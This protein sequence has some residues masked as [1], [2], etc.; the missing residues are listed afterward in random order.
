MLGRLSTVAAVLALAGC[1]G[2]KPVPPLDSAERDE[3]RRLCARFDDTTVRVRAVYAGHSISAD[4]YL[5]ALSEAGLRALAYDAVDVSTG[6]VAT[7]EDVSDTTRQ[8]GFWT[9]LTLGIV[10][11]YAT[12]LHAHVVRA[13]DSDGRQGTSECEE[14]ES[15]GLGWLGVPFALLPGWTSP[16]SSVF[17]GP[18]IYLQERPGDR[19]AL[20]V[21]R[22]LAALELQR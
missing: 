4:D 7:I 15:L 18:R 14:R 5:K 6:P 12:S 21:A 17:W 11:T 13:T 9:Y 1:G 22:A 20:C 8:D 10:P 3:L 2:F 19:L 16:G